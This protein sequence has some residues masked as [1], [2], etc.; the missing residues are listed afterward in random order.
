MSHFSTIK[1]TIKNKEYLIAALK[2]ANY[3]F[4]VGSF[5]C[6]GYNNNKT[7]VEIL[8]T[9]QN[10]NYNLGFRK[11]NGYFELI[12]DWYGIKDINS[13]HLLVELE[14]EIKIIE[15]KIKQEY[16]YNTTIKQ[17]EDQG[18]DID[19]E[20]RN[21]GEIHIKLSRLV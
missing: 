8:I 20:L 14:D 19:E 1:T 16:A 5:Q 13:N 12:A 3:Q 17:L 21:N 6:N 15:N 4:K 9:L 2:K 18:F 7:D 11:N 10:T